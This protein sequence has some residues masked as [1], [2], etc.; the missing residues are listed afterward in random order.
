MIVHR[1][2]IVIYPIIIM[3][4]VVV[5]VVIVKMRYDILVSANFGL[6][7][8]QNATVNASSR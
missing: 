3:I 7:S 5:V 1:F 6:L 4:V 2:N 8:V